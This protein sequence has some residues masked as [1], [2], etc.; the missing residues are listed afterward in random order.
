[1]NTDVF[2]IILI[3]TVFIVQGYTVNFDPIWELNT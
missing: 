2:W 1:M 3:T